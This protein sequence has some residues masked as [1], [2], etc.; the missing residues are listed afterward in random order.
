MPH[1]L[2]QSVFALSHS[3]SRLGESVKAFGFR[4]PDQEPWYELLKHKLVRQI[5]KR[6]FLVVAV[7]G[8]TNTGK[9]V[10]FNHLVGENASAADH[11][12]AGTKHPVCLVPQDT[13]PG[14]G[15]TSYDQETVE[16]IL[17]R[18]FGSFQI[19][20][21]V[22]P[23]D[24]L[25][26]NHE[27]RLF[28][29]VG[30]NVPPNLLLL[31]TPDI[32]SDTP[33][34]WERA[35]EIRETSDLILAVLTEQKY[36]DAAVKRFFREASAA[37]KPVIL[38]FNMVDM[39]RDLNEV[40]HWIKQ[41]HDETGTNPANVLIVPHDRDAAGTGNLNFYELRITNDELL[42]DSLVPVPKLSELLLNLHFEQIKTQTLQGALKMI[43]D[44]ENGVMGYLR[45]MEAEAKS[46]G[47][48][49]KTLENAEGI[50]IT[51]PGLPSSLLIEEIRGWWETGRP[52]WTRRIHNSYRTVGNV[53]LLPFQKAL[54]LFK[55]RQT[56]D[57]MV[58][59]QRQEAQTVTLVVEKTIEQLEHLAETKNPVLRS[60]LQELLTGENRKRLLDHAKAAHKTLIPIDD[61][62]REFLRESL[63]QWS[64]ENPG[65][66]KA[67][68]T[69]DLAAAIAR[70]VVTISLVTT[71]FVF[72][73]AALGMLG[74]ATS[75]AIFT[76]T[77]EVLVNKAGDGIKQSTAKLFQ[78]VQEEYARNRARHFFEWFQRELWGTLLTRL[79]QGEKVVESPIFLETLEAARRVNGLDL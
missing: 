56:D 19:Q 68:R 36:A 72:T 45:K 55:N 11:R 44:P 35:R 47:D 61:D 41:F 34:N 33:V 30:K 48:A 20:P 39:Q 37:G 58:E 18:H 77:G 50:E 6:P 15:K 43:C 70:P 9:S 5:S 14:D 4:P 69:L 3:L 31:D 63:Q 49:R 7:M 71:G 75:T 74:A 62:F 22:K 57:P 53:I 51:W 24:P 59:L 65:A 46:W 28:W 1:E 79:E 17:H 78:S 12:A 67:I 42:A 21:W 52:V 25:V 27:H 2:G 40:P 29:R 26:G 23:E 32:D 10:V 54:S 38:L 76:G 60:V 13:A 16:E 73:P 66:M 64:E 8:G